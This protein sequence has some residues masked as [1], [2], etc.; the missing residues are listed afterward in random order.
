MKIKLK[1]KSSSKKR[2]KILFNKKIKRKKSFKNHNLIKKSS[3]RKKRLSKFIFLNI[4]D[5]K[6]INKHFNK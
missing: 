2:F 6:N 3:K 4:N 5:Y 1:T